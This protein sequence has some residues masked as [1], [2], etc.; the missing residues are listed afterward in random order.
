MSQ[1]GAGAGGGELPVHLPLV[2][3]RCLLPGGQ[4]LVEDT[5]V[6]DAALKALAAAPSPRLHR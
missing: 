6:V 2:G 1:L 5:E 4:L 3:I